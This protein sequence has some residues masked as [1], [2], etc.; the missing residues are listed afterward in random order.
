MFKFCTSSNLLFYYELLIG[1]QPTVLE[2][3]VIFLQ[4]DWST[5]SNV[6]ERRASTGNGLFALLSCDFKPMFGQIVFIRI[7][8][9]GNANTV[10]TRHIKREKSSLPV[11]VRRL[12][13]SLPRGGSTGIPQ[14]STMLKFRLVFQTAGKFNSGKS[15]GLAPITVSL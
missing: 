9:L 6:F 3:L 8:T 1:T 5:V 11:V 2:C 4:S 7:K 13:T 14:C 15:V 12:K 10:V